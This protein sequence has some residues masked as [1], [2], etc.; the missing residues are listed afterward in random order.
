[1][2][3]SRRG[4]GRSRAP[5]RCRTRAGAAVKDALSLLTTLGRRGGGLS[6]RALPWFPVVGLALGGLLGGWWWLAEHWWPVAV[7]AVLVVFADLA[8]TGM[9]HFDGLAD[10]ADALLPH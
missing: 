8:L 4:D 6:A 9:L 5:G 10:S 3:S 2:Q 7:A 1:M